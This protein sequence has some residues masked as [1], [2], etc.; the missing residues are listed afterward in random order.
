VWQR[1]NA[2]EVVRYRCFQA[3][4]S[5]TFSVQSE[6]HYHLP[7]D[8]KQVADLDKQFLELLFEQSPADRSGAYASVSEA[9]AAHVESFGAWP[10]TVGGATPGG[11]SDAS[12]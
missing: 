3:L 1:R 10:F 6:D 2:F 4:S 12:G 5:G 9:I 8:P 7:L 11:V